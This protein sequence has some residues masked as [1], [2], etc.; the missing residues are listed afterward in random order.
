[1]CVINLIQ[2]TH[3]TVCTADRNGFNLATEMHVCCAS[4]HC[5]SPG[6][7]EN[8][9]LNIFNSRLVLATPDTATDGD[10]ARIEGKG[11]SASLIALL[12]WLVPAENGQKGLKLVTSLGA[13]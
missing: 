7:M 13:F 11:S 12:G 8:K 1:M 5:C 9:S 6:A 4:W 10:F 3:G 2:G